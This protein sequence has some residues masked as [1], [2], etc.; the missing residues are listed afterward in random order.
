MFGARAVSAGRRFVSYGA[1][2]GII[3]GLAAVIGSFPAQAAT[4][5]VNPGSTIQSGISSAAAGDTVLVRAGTYTA[6]FTLNRSVQ[7]TAEPGVIVNGTNSGRAVSIQCSDCGVTGF[8]FN[9]FA[10]GIGADNIT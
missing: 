1:L 10:Y 2:T 8:T 6:G 3:G 4:I 5:T 7:V 9:N